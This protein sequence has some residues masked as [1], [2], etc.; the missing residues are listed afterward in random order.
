[1]LVLSCT[2]KA[3]MYITV[4]DYAWTKFGQWVYV[5]SLAVTKH[6]KPNH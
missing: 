6:R 5:F 2:V 4:Y 1:M 3:C